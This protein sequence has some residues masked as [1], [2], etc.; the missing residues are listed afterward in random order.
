[1]DLA[2]RLVSIGRSARSRA[3]LKVR[4]PLHRA[5]VALPP[6]S[7]LLLVDIIAEELNVDE[8]ILAD[9][10]GEV[11]SFELVP[12]FRLLGPRLGRA[13][14]EVAPALANIDSQAAAAELERGAT[15]QLDLSTGPV[16][17]GAEDI[18]IRVRSKEGFAVS[19][20]GT[21]A[22]ALDT[23]LDEGL[24]RRGL[25][26]DIV[27]QI[28]ELRRGLGLA[29]SDR[30]RLTLSGVDELSEHADDLGH[31][32]LATEVTFGTGTGVG[33]LLET[34]DHRRAYA[35]IEAA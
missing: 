19:R 12:N 22:V 32:V 26:R 18:D 1:M 34:D 6:G 14:K 28:Q 11:L 17:L 24:R 31:D 10:L 5:I 15:I 4:Q 23:D 7:P 25:L 29:V 30:V 8:V 20:Q 2:R 33:S 21:E 13:V 9:T 35:W 16:H 27:R 3:G